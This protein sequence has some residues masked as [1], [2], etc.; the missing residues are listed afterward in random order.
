MGYRLEMQDPERHWIWIQRLYPWLDLAV[1]CYVVSQHGDIY[2]W[3]NPEGSPKCCPVKKGRMS[4]NGCPKVP[5]DLKK[6]KQNFKTQSSPWLKW[7]PPNYQV[8]KGNHLLCCPPPIMLCGLVPPHQEEEWFSQNRSS[9]PWPVLYCHEQKARSCQSPVETQKD[10]GLNKKTG[11]NDFSVLLLL[12]ITHLPVALKTM[13]SPPVLLRLTLTVWF[14]CF[15]HLC[16]YKCETQMCAHVVNDLA[17][18]FPWRDITYFLITLIT[19]SDI[20][21][22]R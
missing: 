11:K 12:S 16:V 3:R 14:A 21:I 1:H 17:V 10:N 18:Q 15:K 20:S 22:K 13:I 4:G 6:T 19:N 5:L 8:Q 9:R 2:L 7:C